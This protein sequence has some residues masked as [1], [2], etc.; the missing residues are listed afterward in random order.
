MIRIPKDLSHLST[1][2]ASMMM[3]SSDDPD[4]GDVD[5]A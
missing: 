3:R 2:I 5:D 4:N 1:L